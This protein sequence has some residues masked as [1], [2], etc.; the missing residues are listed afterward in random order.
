[1]TFCLARSGEFLACFIR[2]NNLHRSVIFWPGGQLRFVI[3]PNFLI[4]GR[5]IEAKTEE[6]NNQ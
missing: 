6:F 3:E 5:L 2:K 1:M 4:G